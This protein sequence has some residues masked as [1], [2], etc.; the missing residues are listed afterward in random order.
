V[1]AI[2]EVKVVFP[3][4]QTKHF[5]EIDEGVKA[6]KFLYQMVHNVEFL[7]LRLENKRVVDIILINLVV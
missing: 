4:I 3:T 6:M 1:L 2:F 7:A 5:S